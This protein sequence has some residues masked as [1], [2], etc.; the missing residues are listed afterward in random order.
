MISCLDAPETVLP[1]YQGN[2]LNKTTFTIS[3][4]SVALLLTNSWWVYRLVDAGISYTHQGV[5]LEE[6]RKALSGALAIITTLGSGDASREQVIQ[7][8][9]EAWPSAEPFEKDDYVWIGR[10]GLRFD[11]SGRLVEVI[12]GD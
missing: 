2:M 4:L 10:L 7:A 9:L 8:V 6:E 1:G 12:S 3:L 11:D 5:S